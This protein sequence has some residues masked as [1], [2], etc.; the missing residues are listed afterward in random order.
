MVNFYG[1]G[2]SGGGLL[3]KGDGRRQDERPRQWA[4]RWKKGALLARK[5]ES[6]HHFFAFFAVARRIIVETMG[7]GGCKSTSSSRVN[8]AMTAKK[9]VLVKERQQK[10]NSEPNFYWAHDEEPHRRR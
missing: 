8:N 10:I 5:S 9:E 3:D 4:R 7:K 6:A 2:N 1:V